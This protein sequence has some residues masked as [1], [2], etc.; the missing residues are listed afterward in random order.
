LLLGYR[1]RAQILAACLHPAAA[2]T[3]GTTAF[4][5]WESA[6]IGVNSNTWN[7][8]NNYNVT[9]QVPSYDPYL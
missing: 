2:F 5:E 3:Y 1:S 8:S 4:A 7:V 6:N 9:L